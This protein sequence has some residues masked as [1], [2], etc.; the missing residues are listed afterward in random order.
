MTFDE[1]F[2]LGDQYYIQ[3][4]YKK[5]LAYFLKCLEL[6]ESYDCDNYIGC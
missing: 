1:Y 5:A 6:D 2:E 4:D 3:G